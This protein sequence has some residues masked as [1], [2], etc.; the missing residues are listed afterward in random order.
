MT[1][2]LTDEEIEYAKKLEAQRKTKLVSHRKKAPGVC[3]YCGKDFVGY[4]TKKT[5]SLTC[6]VGLWQQK[7]RELYN[8]RQNAKKKR[9]RQARKNT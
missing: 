2:I 8:E 1:A 9:Q 4:T 5:C 3:A 6:R 7:N